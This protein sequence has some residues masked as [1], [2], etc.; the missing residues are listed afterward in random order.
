M[1]VYIH[2]YIYIHICIYTDIQI[3]TDIYTYRYN[4]PDVKQTNCLT[5]PP[6]TKIPERPHLHITLGPQKAFLFFSSS[7]QSQMNPVVSTGPAWH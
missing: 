1:Y 6:R 3:Y 5:T 7:N 4:V 2:L